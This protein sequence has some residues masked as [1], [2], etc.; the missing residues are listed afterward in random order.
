MFKLALGITS[1]EFVI[2]TDGQFSMKYPTGELS[3]NPLKIEILSRQGLSIDVFGINNY[4][5]GEKVKSVQASFVY[6]ADGTKMVDF[7]KGWN[8]EKSLDKI[9]GQNSSCTV[10]T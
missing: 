1:H 6:V 8:P 3:E 7:R 4:S 2:S 10:T 9:Y 5:R